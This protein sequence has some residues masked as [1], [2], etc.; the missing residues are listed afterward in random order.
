MNDDQAWEKYPKHHKWFNKLWLAEELGYVCGQLPI[1]R[2][3]FY[4]K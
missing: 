2:L 1:A 3:G 4:A